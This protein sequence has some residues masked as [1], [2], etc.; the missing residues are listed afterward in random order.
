MSSLVGIILLI[1]VAVTIAILLLNFFDVFSQNQMDNIDN[2]T[3]RDDYC[4]R[5]AIELENMC[6]FVEIGGATPDP[7]LKIELKNAGSIDIEDINFSLYEE[8]SGY[9]SGVLNFGGIVR[10]GISR[11]Q[12]NDLPNGNDFDRM[13]LIPYLLTED[14]TIITC[15][16]I[17]LELNPYPSDC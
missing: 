14:G 9:D 8:D 11:Q 10:Y 15:D 7:E 2:E 13:T 1:G 6:S 12:F 3:F 5:V 4:G 17:V 16:T